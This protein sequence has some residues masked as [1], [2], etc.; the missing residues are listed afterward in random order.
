[1]I[2]YAATNGELSSQSDTEYADV[3]MNRNIEE[4]AKSYLPHYTTNWQCSEYD[5]IFKRYIF[6]TRWKTY[7]KLALNRLLPE[8][9]F[10]I[11]TREVRVYSDE[12]RANERD[13]NNKELFK[14]NNVHTKTSVPTTTIDEEEN[15]TILLTSIILWSVCLDDNSNEW[16]KLFNVEHFHIAFKQRN[17]FREIMNQND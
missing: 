2:R 10:D 13:K 8:E 15:S 4:L 11:A 9:D 1:M 16:L 14:T 5:E 6:I 7:K 17:I 12:V 3:K